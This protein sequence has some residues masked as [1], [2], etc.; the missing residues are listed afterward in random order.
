MSRVPLMYW[1]VD[2]F[3]DR[4]FAGNPAA[5]VVV[6]GGREVAW[7]QALAME[8]NLAETAFVTPGQD[9]GAW[10]LRWFTPALEVDLCGHATLAAAHVLWE[11]GFLHDTAAAT[12]DTRSGRLTCVKLVSGE[13]AM[14]FPS[15]P[16]VAADFP[17]ALRDLFAE[18]PAFV[19]RCRM[20]WFVELGTE[21]EVRNYA[22]DFGAIER[23]GSGDLGVIITARA[24]SGTDVVSRYFAPAAGVPEDPVTGSA[25]CVIGP[26]WGAKLGRGELTGWQASRG[27]GHVAMKMENG[28]VELRGRAVTVLRGEVLG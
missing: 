3:A 7:M 26:Y 6:P 17:P 1:Q 2:A 4:P 18:A 23:L 10:G 8:N 22:P 27:G 14:D 21:E 16:P 12:F 13:V 24:K 20:G 19:G 11:A 5:V 25:H 9:G 28:R 15:D